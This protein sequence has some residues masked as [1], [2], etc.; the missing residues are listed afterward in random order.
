MN[1]T[2]KPNEPKQWKCSICG[3]AFK[4]IKERANCE[5]MCAHKMEEEIRRAEETQKR[6]EQKNDKA[7]VDHACEEFVKLRNAYVKKYGSYSYRPPVA[8]EQD[9]RLDDLI[10]CIFGGM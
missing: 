6:E 5:L 7:A 2:Q 1:E 4:T 3:A 10:R 8:E 9:T